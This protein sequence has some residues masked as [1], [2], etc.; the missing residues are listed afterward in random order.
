VTVR[1]VQDATAAALPY[2]GSENCV[3]LTLGTAI[4]TGYV[5]ANDA[6]LLPLRLT[7]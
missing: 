3:V 6:G 1:L 2:A 5:P 4:G 7:R